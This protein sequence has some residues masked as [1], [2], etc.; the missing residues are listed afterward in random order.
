MFRIAPDRHERE[1]LAL[2]GE[3]FAGIAVSDR[4]WAYNSLD[5][6]K[7]QACWSHLLRG[8]TFHAEGSGPQTDFGEAGLRIAERGLRGAV[9]YRKLSL[10]SQSEAGEHM[11]ERLLSIS[12]TCR[13]QKRSMLAYLTDALTATARGEPLPTLV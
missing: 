5:P 6:V 12:Q 10:G 2:L 9:I 4:W 3:Q 7:R 13:L 8:F 11:I 1:A